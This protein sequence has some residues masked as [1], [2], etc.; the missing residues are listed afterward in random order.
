M[1]RLKCSECGRT[2]ETTSDKCELCGGEMV[3][4]G[5]PKKPKPKTV[6][7]KREKFNAESDLGKE[8]PGD[9]SPVAVRAIKP[10]VPHRTVLDIGKQDE[11]SFKSKL[12]TAGFIIGTIAVAAVLAFSIR[13][14]FGEYNVKFTDENVEKRQ[15]EKMEES[16]S[17]LVE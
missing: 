13:H 2:A 17:T 5:A 11:R 9:F 14:F 7:P 6:K 16:D 8:S 10:K 3:Q 15:V 4:A 12:K 1:A